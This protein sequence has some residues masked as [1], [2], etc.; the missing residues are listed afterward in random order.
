MH[1]QL[2]FLWLPMGLIAG[3]LGGFVMSGRGF[4]LI[5]D[6]ALGL[7]GSLIGSVLFL[8]F[9]RSPDNGS[10]TLCIGAFLG[11]ASVIVGQRWWYAHVDV[12]E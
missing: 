9:E 10:L 11:A 2:F 1:R 5:A 8:A 12:R 6:L 4:G 7:A 3:G